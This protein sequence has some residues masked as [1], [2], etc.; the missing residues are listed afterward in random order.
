M[1]V[2]GSTAQ[3]LL[4]M[5]TLILQGGMSAPDANTVYDVDGTWYAWNGSTW[6]AA[7]EP[8]E[9]PAFNVLATA[10][11]IASPTAAML[12]RLDVVYRL[13]L[14]PYTRYTSDGTALNI[15]G[16]GASVTAFDS[17][18]DKVT[19]TIATTNTSVANALAARALTTRTVN[20]HPLSADVTVTASDV[21][22]VATSAVGAASGVCPLD[23]GSKVA[24][25][26]LPGF[27]DDVLEYANLAALPGTGTAGII[28]V[29][30]DTNKTY[31]WGGSSY[32]EISPS[33]GST[34]VVT[35]GS[36]NLYHTDARTRASALTG[37]STA[38]AADVTASDT[39]L[40]AFGKLQAKWNAFAASVLGVLLTGLSTADASDVA[41]TD[42][43]LVS[44]G[45]FQ[46]KWNAIATTIR[47]TVLTGFST[48]VS[49]AV[50]AGDTILAAF[51]KIQAQYNNA[52]ARGQFGIVYKPYA[53]AAALGEFSAGVT[54]ASTAITVALPALG[55]K[56]R[57]ML[58]HQWSGSGTNTRV[59]NLKLN[60]T[61]LF[62]A[63]Q[64]GTYFNMVHGFINK[65]ATNA[66]QGISAATGGGGWGTSSSTAPA[67]AA[68]DTSVATTL[69]L[70]LSKGLAGD[71]CN[72]DHWM[73]LIY[74]PDL[75]TP[76]LSVNN[77][78]TASQSVTSVAATVGGTDVTLNAA[79]SN[80]WKFTMPAGNRNLAAP[81]NLVDGTSFNI[82]ITQDSTARSLTYDAIYVFPTGQDTTLPTGAGAVAVL[83]GIYY[84]DS[85]KI[86]CSLSK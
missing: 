10:A 47:G 46:A 84:A 21:S 30:L 58:Y 11:E 45:K 8:N 36:T 67:T 41:A 64:A 78:W 83:S 77:V 71:V 82:K 49:T 12:A 63:S 2:I 48:A 55:A 22:A 14:A 25:I 3:N 43:L 70:E 79:L 9:Y 81:T 15:I 37:L 86:Y 20:G 44:A 5:K 4:R 27:V 85:G 59:F 61:S 7:F 1:N 69:T 56:A 13:N 66:Q 6:I 73:V 74:D 38:S 26:Y 33:P 35:E 52:I 51:G 80:N 29:T 34:D 40:S 60:G 57:V 65:N 17:L 53:A 18:T 75:A 16:S 50:V 72:L 76:L 31:R 32:T 54:T 28:Y 42:S 24:A 62:N 39:V 19:A 23:S 68:I